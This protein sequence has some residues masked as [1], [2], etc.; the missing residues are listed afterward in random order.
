MLNITVRACVYSACARVYKIYT[1]A[2]IIHA[3]MHTYINADRQ[4]DRTDRH[5]TNKQTDAVCE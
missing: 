2:N 4:I 3:Y 1:T 5:Q